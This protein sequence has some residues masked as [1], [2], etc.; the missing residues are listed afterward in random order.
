MGSN[1]YNWNRTSIYS[2]R[3]WQT[4]SAGRAII[5]QWM[6]TDCCRFSHPVLPDTRRLAP[7]GSE[8]LGYSEPC[9]LWDVAIVGQKYRL[10][11]FVQGVL[12]ELQIQERDGVL[13]AWC[14]VRL[15]HW[16]YDEQ[17]QRNTSGKFLSGF[18]TLYVNVYYKPWVLRGSWS[19]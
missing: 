2:L 17:R 11:D 1:D 12:C 9:N 8:V 5:C 3:S 10:D 13:S 16:I 14:H 7:E 15:T 6:G 4:K 19:C 18:I